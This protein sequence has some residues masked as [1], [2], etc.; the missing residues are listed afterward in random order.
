MVCLVHE[1]TFPAGKEDE[2]WQHMCVHVCVCPC[3]T[4]TYPPV[5]RLHQHGAL[6]CGRGGLRLPPAGVSSAAARDELGLLT[7]EQ[8]GEFEGEISCVLYVI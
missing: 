8:T 5:L 6:P 7:F 4:K 2:Q 3:G 1:S